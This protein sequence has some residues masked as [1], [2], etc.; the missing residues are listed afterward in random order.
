MFDF[1]AWSGNVFRIIEELEQCE[2]N[3]E[4]A[5]AIRGAQRLVGRT[6]L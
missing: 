4:Q 6:S 1:E 3:V 5:D 2:G